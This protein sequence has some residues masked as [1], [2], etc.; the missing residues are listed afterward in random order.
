[1]PPRRS[2]R[3]NASSGR[4]SRPYLSDQLDWQLPQYVDAPVTPLS[5]DQIEAIHNASLDI[6]ENTG[7]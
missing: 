4:A 6:I 7:I 1:M 3:R 5:T 2:S